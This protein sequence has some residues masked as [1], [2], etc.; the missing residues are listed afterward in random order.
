MNIGK[1]IKMCRTSLGLSQGDLAQKI[2]MSMSYI[3]LIE[4][5]KRDPA[6]STIEQIAD[7]LGV[8]VSLLTFLAAD[9]NELKGV[10]EDLRDRLSGVAF[11]LLHAKQRA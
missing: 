2:G 7:A 5:G 9:P 1:S 6:I 3:S 4:K 8:P 11:R 10:P